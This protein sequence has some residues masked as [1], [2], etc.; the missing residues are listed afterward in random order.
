MAPRRLRARK[1]CGEVYKRFGVF[2]ARV[3]LCRGAGM[4]LSQFAV[5]ARAEGILR[6]EFHRRS[7][8]LFELW[9]IPSALA[10]NES[11]LSA[12]GVSFAPA[13]AG[14]VRARH[15]TPRRPIEGHPGA[16]QGAQSKLRGALE[17]PTSAARDRESLR[18]VLGSRTGFRC[19]HRCGAPR[20]FLT[21][22]GC[23]SAGTPTRAC[24]HPRRC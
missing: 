17:K 20:S 23:R 6:S 4:S 12:W 19:S 16:I 13:E 14:I 22:R 9:S 21:G 8:G 10:F 11:C 18:C 2:V 7:R 24:R 5:W 3:R 1:L 15:T